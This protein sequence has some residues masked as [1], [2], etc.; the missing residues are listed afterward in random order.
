MWDVLTVNFHRSTRMH[1]G[2]SRNVNYL[3]R[4]WD[5]EIL[6]ICYFNL[7]ISFVLDFYKTLCT[8]FRNEK[9]HISQLVVSMLVF[10]SF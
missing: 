4:N 1:E 3:C 5:I 8:C 6:T 10:L 9:S 7:G 2:I